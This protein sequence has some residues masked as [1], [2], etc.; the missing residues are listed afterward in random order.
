MSAPIEEK[1]ATSVVEIMNEKEAGLVHLRVVKGSEAYHE[2]KLKEPPRLMHPVT[3]RLIGCL[4][5]GCFCQTMNGFDGSLFGGLS[6]NKTFLTF[7]N[8]SEDGPWQAINSAMYQIGGVAALPFVGPAI[9]T[10]GRKAGM[11]IG[12]WIIIVGTIINGTTV[13]TGDGG[14]LKGGRFILGFGVSIVSAAGPIY[15]VE[16][17]HPSWRGIITAYCNTFWFT[18]SILAAGAVRGGMNLAGNTSWLL[19]VWMQLVFP[20]LIAIFV[21]VIPESPRWLFVNNKREKAVQILTKWH[22]YGNPNSIWVKLEVSEYEEYLNTNGADKRFWDYSA[23][24]G[25]RAARYRIACNCVFAIFAQWAGNGVLSYFLPAVLTTAGYTDSVEKANINLGYS[26]FQFA[27]A[28]TG[29]A[30]VDRIGRRPLM[31]FSMT[32]CCIVWIGVTAATAMFAESGKTNEAAARA[33]VAC[34]FIFGAT[35]SVGLTPLQALYP[36]EVLSFEG[37]AKGMAFSSLAVNAG[38]LLNQ[39]AWPISLRNIGWKTYIVFVIWCA[40]QATVFYF[41]LPETKGRT[42]EELDKIFEAPNP[43]KESL[44]A[45]KLAVANDGT[46]LASEDA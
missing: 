11:S 30:F 21:W 22:G 42:L 33:T 45:H 9:D 3:L 14:Q 24:F 32:G 18:G 5:L 1:S 7:F 19:P 46:V 28:L 34:I 16:T 2:A 13:F 43:V 29:A 10:W 35:Y 40:V 17:A 20:G 8:G 25:S 41:F 38:N 39:F 6:A 31:L 36:V 15:V 27:F 12:A 37:R 4:L 26:C 44:K 23:L